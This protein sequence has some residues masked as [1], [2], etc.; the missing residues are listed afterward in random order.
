MKATRYPHILKT[1]LD[2][3]WALLPS[4]LGMIVDI[5]RF[6]A[7]G[8]EL[9]AEDIQQRI[10]AAQNGPRRGGG[11]AGVVAVIPI[12]GV[13]SPRQNLFSETSGGTSVE[14]LT[15]SF[16]EA[17]AD[18][19]VSAIVF[20]VDSPG[21]HVDGLEELGVEIRNARGGEKPIVAVANTMAASAAYWL[22]SQA[23]EI[24]V[25]PSGTVGSVGVI[26][27]HQDLSAAYEAGGIRTTIITYGDHKSE[28]NEY[29]PL[30]D[31]ARAEIQ[32]HVTHYGHMFEAAVS[33]GRK[34][35]V[36]AIRKSYG[37][38][39]MLLPKEAVSVGAADR[40]DTLDNTVRRL[41]RG[42]YQPVSTNQSAL[43]PESP[44]SL[45]ALVAALPFA[46][47]LQL[48][49]AEVTAIAEHARYRADLR[50]EEGRGL[51][52]ATREQLR[53]L[54]A[55]RPVLDEI[56]AL[57]VVDS[58]VPEPLPEPDPPAPKSRLPLLQ[59]ME[60]AARGGY[61]LTDT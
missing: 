23:E 21:G 51:S 61:H 45:A 9:A 27:A 28:G 11:R 37:Q 29:E 5:V 32:R 22:A 59:L 20:D 26:A 17:L 57:A 58:P 54:L 38:G 16:R 30:S 33:K 56:D 55:L 19:E 10:A 25:T 14:Q 41:G 2:T 1:V 4:T 49:A 60:A 7:E 42:G 47:R 44:D 52:V 36:E 43:V 46:E 6:R 31:E 24:V 3:P 39:R 8:G 35:S 53:E 15:S 18:R 50:A 13:I 34:V 40:I 12:Y 48:V